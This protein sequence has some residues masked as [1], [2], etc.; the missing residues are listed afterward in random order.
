MKTSKQQPFFSW[1][2]T[3]VHHRIEQVGSSLTALKGLR[4]EV[5][6]IGQV[7][8]AV[9]AAVATMTGVQ[10]GL[11]SFGLGLLHHVWMFAI[12]SRQTLLA[13]AN[14]IVARRE[15]RSTQRHEACAV[16]NRAHSTKQTARC[17]FSNAP[18]FVSLLSTCSS[19]LATFRQQ[20]T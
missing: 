9:D 20:Q 10:I 13:V 11:E 4:N 15:A 3:Y 8:P 1:T 16:S 14:V 2:T 18:S 5:I 7:C 17:A 19:V 6:V 12:S